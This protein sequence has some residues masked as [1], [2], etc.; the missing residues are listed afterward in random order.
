MDLLEAIGLAAIDSL[1]VKVFYWP[2]RISLKVVTLGKYP[3]TLDTPHNKE[4]VAVAGLLVFVLPA[5][6]YAML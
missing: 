3:P 4:L 1:F 5:I 2:G 6:G